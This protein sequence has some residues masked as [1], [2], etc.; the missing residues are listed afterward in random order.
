MD[1]DYQQFSDIRSLIL[2]AIPSHLASIFDHSGAIFGHSGV[3]LG[4]FWPHEGLPEALEARASKK[5]A[6]GADRL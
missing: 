5:G 4:T 6:P 3:I 2:Q 1:N